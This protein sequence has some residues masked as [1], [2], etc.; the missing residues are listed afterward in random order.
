[1]RALGWLLVCL[2]AFS[3]DDHEHTESRAAPARSKPA[4]TAATPPTS[5]KVTQPG[6]PPA[7]GRS[8]STLVRGTDASGHERAPHDPSDLGRSARPAIVLLTAKWCQFCQLLEHDTLASPSV[9]RQLDQ[10]WDYLIADV[11]ESPAWLDLAGVQGLPTLAFFDAAGRHVLSK[12]GYRDA[13]GVE[14]LLVTAR[15]SIE[16]RTLTPYATTR[17]APRLSPSDITDE[18]A[19]ALLKRL[20]SFVFIRVNSNDG[21]FH[22]PARHPKPD[23][24]LELAHWAELGAPDRVSRWVSLTVESALRGSSPRLSGDPLPS[25]RWSAQQV[26]RLAALDGASKHWRDGVLALPA[27]DPFRGL[28]DPFDHG[29]FRYAAGPGWYHPHFERRAMDNLSWVLLLRLRHQRDR[30]ARIERFVMHTFARGS[31]LAAVQRSNPFYYRLRPTERRLVAPPPVDALL[32]PEVQARA[33]RVDASRCD[34]LMRVDGMT[35]PRARWTRLGEDS[36][37]PA[38]LPDAV[39]EL[40]LGLASC[41]GEQAA[42]RAERLAALVVDRWSRS[43]PTM[44][45]APHRLYRLAAGLCAAESPACRRALATLRSV[46]PNIDSAPPFSALAR[47]TSPAPHG[48]GN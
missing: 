11:D 39:G 26:L 47:A 29:V 36:Q 4:P 19:K 44:G 30:A 31:L 17:D 2:G 5:S 13:G 34:R 46:E 7:S 23:L 25:F 41:P 45:A 22:T 3:C 37:A 12:S 21:G 35:W 10:H 1:M 9:R 40:L 6:P 15:R 38:A 32:L 24:L 14:D 28:Q 18:E 42:Q 48:S 20:E 43:A 16:E 27:A 33:A 8:R